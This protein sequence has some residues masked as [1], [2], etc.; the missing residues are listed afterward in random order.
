MRNAELSKQAT[1]IRDLI[2]NTSAATGGDLELQSHWAKYLC[3]LS[4]G[5]VE[6]ATQ[7]LYSNYVLK[8]TPE[9]VAKFAISKIKR[10]QNPKSGRLVE[11]ATSFNKDWGTNLDTFIALD[12][13]LEAINA[14]MDNRHLIAHGKTSD[15][16]V[17][18]ISKYFD[19]IVQVAEFIEN[20]LITK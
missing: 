17:Y 8:I 16:T 11:I 13:R 3:V 18:R 6:N 14:V 12:G 19:K 1:T 20:Q 9:P 4:V 5:Y 2:K 7:V 10:I 15:I